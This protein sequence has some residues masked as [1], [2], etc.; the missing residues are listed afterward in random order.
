MKVTDKATG[1]VSD[2]AVTL[3]QDEGPRADTTLAGLPALKP[4]F[5]DGQRIKAG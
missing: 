2:K 3:K 5:A 1:A 4:V